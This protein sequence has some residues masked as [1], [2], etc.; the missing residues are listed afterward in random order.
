MSPARKA[1]TGRSGGFTM[2]ELVI[3]I[4]V[5][6]V[7]AAF[8]IARYADLAPDARE[9]VRDGV[10]GAIYAAAAKELAENRQAPNTTQIINALELAGE[11]K[12]DR[13]SA[14]CKFDI[15]VETTTYSDYVDLTGSRLC[16]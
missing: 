1:F 5:L 3:V 11:V 8:A 9:A 14:A 7:L 4:V 2:T 12:V 6:G 16:Q 13:G 15:T 10:A